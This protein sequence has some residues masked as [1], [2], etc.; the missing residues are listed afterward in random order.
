MAKKTKNELNNSDKQFGKLYNSLWF[1]L[2]L[3]G[4]NKND[5]IESDKHVNRCRHLCF[6]IRS[7]I[8][9]T[10]TTIGVLLVILHVCFFNP[11]QT[12][13]ELCIMLA[14]FFSTFQ[15]VF[16]RGIFVFRKEKISK[17]LLKLRDSCKAISGKDDKVY[18]E[19]RRFYRLNG[20]VNVA[21][22]AC[23]TVMLLNV[24]KSYKS[25]IDLRGC[26]LSTPI[27]STNSSNSELWSTIE[28]AFIAFEFSEVMILNT[29][30]I[31]FYVLTC[32]LVQTNF[33]YLAHTDSEVSAVNISNFLEKYMSLCE[34]VELFEEIFS[35]IVA[36]WA[37]NDTFS[38]MMI[39]R[40]IDFSTLASSEKKDTETYLFVVVGVYQFVIK[41]HLAAII[42]EKVKTT[43]C[44]LHKMKTSYESISNNSTD[45]LQ[46]TVDFFRYNV[47]ID[48]PALTGWKLYHISKGL[49]LNAFA[50]VLTYVLVLY[51]IK[52]NGEIIT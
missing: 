46:I 22:Y 3:S 31:S 5:Y 25:S 39:L 27:F 34:I 24:N 40:M 23:L 1:L 14:S 4:I 42:N 35:E 38:L 13:E 44:R 11:D 41:A 51:N 32:K 7:I 15:V 30:F 21:A 45:D 43:A 33:K 20:A 47:K 49:I 52:D 2:M 17:L 37:F 26:I 9:H 19:V 6:K 28:V 36:F 18:H 10:T 8:F 29:V 16:L 48:P 50:Y 12:I